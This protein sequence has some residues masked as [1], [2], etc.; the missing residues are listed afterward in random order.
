[1]RNDPGR[2]FGLAPALHRPLTAARHLLFLGALLAA[3]LAAGCGSPSP[4]PGASPEAFRAYFDAQIPAWMDAAGVPGAAVAVVENG[5]PAWSRAYGVADRASG[6]R[7]TPSTVFRVESISKSV[8]A[9]GVMKQVEEGNLA[10]DDPVS[11]HLQTWHLPDYSDEPQRVTIRRLLSH[12]AGLARGPIGEEYA[13]GAPVPD[14]RIHLSRAVRFADAPGAG[15]RY[16]NAGFNLLQ[17]LLEDVTGRAFADYMRDA[18]LTPLGMHHARFQGSDSLFAALPTGYER[19]GAPVAPYVYPAVASGGLY[20]SVEDVARFVAAEVIG[21]FPEQPVLRR[22]T[23]RAMH[24]PVVEVR[25]LF[26]FVADAYALGHFVE[27]LPDGR[28]AVW[29]GGQGHGWMT[30]FHAVPASGDGIVIL[31][32]SERAWPLMARILDAWATWI[33]AGSVGMSII[34]DAT[35]ALQGL[36]VLLA[37][38]VLGGTARLVWGLRTGARR[39]HPL[40]GQARAARIGEALLGMALLAGL[41][42]AALQPYLFVTSIFPT[43]VGWAAAVLAGLGL[44]FLA[45]ALC[46]RQTLVQRPTH[47]ETPETG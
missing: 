18:L 22:E 31:T 26:G 35:V 25:G 43:T 37:L 23:I 15:F 12:T 36:T 45:R 40:A 4:R 24:E 6:R 13:P 16:S 7:M 30:H 29:H 47:P 27:T 17:L 33:G 42:W 3:L 10:L 39:V 34:T 20:A 19:T 11:D 46:P 41:A 38:L 9:W 8:T 21:P 28:R 1:M 2:R 5:R 14:L 32:N 44:L